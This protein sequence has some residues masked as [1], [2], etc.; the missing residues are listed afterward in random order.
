MVRG[1]GRGGTAPGTLEEFPLE[2]WGDLPLERYT[3]GP[4]AGALPGRSFCRLMEYGTDTF[5]S[6]RGGSAAKHIIFQHRGGG[7]RI[8]PASL[9]DIEPRE[10]WNRVRGE[11]VTAFSAAKEQAYGRIDELESLS[12]GQALTT[13]ALAVYFPDEFLPV[14]SFSR[15]RDADKKY[16]ALEWPTAGW[17]PQSALSWA[18]T[19]SATP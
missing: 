3:L 17:C 18:A 16:A 7:W 12:Y 5:G 6:I 8:V 4:D 13:K 11:F 9:R 10:A 2:K 1:Q 19:Q 15:L 14:F